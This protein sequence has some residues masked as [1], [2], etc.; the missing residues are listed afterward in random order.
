MNVWRGFLWRSSTGYGKAGFTGKS[1]LRISQR[2]PR[3]LP[4]AN[5]ECHGRKGDRD[6]CAWTRYI[7]AIG[8]G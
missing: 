1:I 3:K 6:T 5:V 7:K 4:S 8:M 2:A